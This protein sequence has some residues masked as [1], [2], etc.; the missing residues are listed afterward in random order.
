MAVIYLTRLPSRGRETAD[1]LR[2]RH[3]DG[4]DDALDMTRAK[5]PDAVFTTADRLNDVL[6]K[7]RNMH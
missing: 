3:V 2:S 4:E 7:I 1:Y 6:A 5:A